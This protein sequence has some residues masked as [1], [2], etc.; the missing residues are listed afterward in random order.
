M[1]APCKGL[2]TLTLSELVSRGAAGMGITLPAGA[3]ARFQTYYDLLVRRNQEMN[4]TAITGEEDAARLHMLDSLALLSMADFQGKSA[5][6]VGS[7]AGFPGMPLLL[8]QPTM[9]LTL[10]DAQEKRVGFLRELCTALGVSAS[11]VHARAEEAGRGPMRDSFDFAV[12]RAVAR[13]N[14]LCELCMPLV[15]PGGLFIAMKSVESDEEIAEARNAVGQLGGSIA[16]IR[17]YPVPDA[18]VIH[19]AVLIRKEKPTPAVYPRRFARIQKQP[20]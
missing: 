12:S 19:R 17:D 11:C 3:P 14:L 18:G 8:A 20:L 7:G 13:L 4:L 5:V 1:P 6:D 10:L 9:K 15:K 2:S 16:E